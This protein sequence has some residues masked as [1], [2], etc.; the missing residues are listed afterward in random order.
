MDPSVLDPK[1]TRIAEDAFVARGAVVVGDVH[2]GALASIWF[3]CVVRGDSDVIRIGPRVNVQDGTIVHVDEGCPAILEEGVSIGHA[4]VIHG[5]TLG[6]GSLIGM[7]SIVMN[8]VELG[9]DCLVGA[10][11]LV[12][13]GKVF[14]PRSMIL[15]R[16]GKVVRELGDAEVALLR[17]ATDH[18]V[19]AGQLYRSR[20]HGAP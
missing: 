12:T 7:G 9:E 15:G 8:G 1:R 14:P 18:Y 19:E 13:E 17:R 16:P 6:R 2:V 10:G 4:C 20:G 5:C 11:S 3:G